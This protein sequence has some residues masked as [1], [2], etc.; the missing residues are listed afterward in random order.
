MAALNIVHA[1]KKALLTATNNNDINATAKRKVK[2]TTYDGRE[3]V[4]DHV[5]VTCSLGVL[6]RHS[7]TLFQPLLPK[8]KLAAIHR[9]RNPRDVFLRRKYLC[10]MGF[11]TVNKLILQYNKPWWSDSIDGVQFAWLKDVPLKLKSVAGSVWDVVYLLW[12]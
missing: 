10:R 5:I 11:G 3:Y 9:W 2:I 12:K 8:D 4:C 1:D 7:E 6:K